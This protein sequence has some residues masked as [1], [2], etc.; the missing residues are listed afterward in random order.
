MGVL[1]T[2]KTVGTQPAPAGAFDCFVLAPKGLDCARVLRAAARA[3][4]IGLVQGDAGALAAGIRAATAAGVSRLGALAG[5]A[6]QIAALSGL[7][8]PA[9]D[10]VMAPVEVCLE[11]KPHV[12][13]LRRQGVR[14]LCIATRCEARSLDLAGDVDGYVLKGHECAGLVSEQTAF[15]LLQG[16]ARQTALPLYIQGGVTPATAAAARVGGAAGVVLDDEIMLL[17]ETGLA[18]ETLR[19][20]IERLSGSETLQVEHPT[21]D[22][23][24]RGLG[25]PGARQADE[26]TRKLHQIHAEES[27]EESGQEA[28]LREMATIADGFSWAQDASI[29]PGGQGLALAAPLARKYATLGRL[30]GAIG[31]AVADLPAAAAQRRALA[32]GG[33]LAEMFGTRYP[34]VQGPMT[35][36]SD[37]SDFSRHVGAAGALPMAALSLLKGADV[38]KLLAETRDQMQGMPWGVGMLGFAPKEVL[39]PQFAAVDQVRPDFA[40]IAGGRPD[41]VA[42]FEDMGIQTFVHASTVSL[43]CGNLEDGM[44]RFIIEGRECGGHIGPLTSFVLWGAIVEALLDHPVITKQGSKVQIVFAGGIH[45]AA[46]AAMVATLGEPLA[47]KGVKIGVLMGTGYLFTREIVASGAILPDYQSVALACDSTQ[48]LWEGPGY[49]NRCAHTPIAE[50]IRHKRR[51][52]EA[53]GASVTEVRKAIEAVSL[54]RLRMASKGIA[55]LGADSPITQIDKDQRYRE[56]MYMIGQVAAFHDQTLTIA[57][58]HQDVSAGSVAHLQ[59]FA[60]PRA[61]VAAEPAPP[62]ADIAIVGMGTLLPG[63]ETLAAYW[64][65]ILSGESAI[66]EVP[67]DRWDQAAYFN[68]DRSA[69]DRSY[70]RWGGFLED[71]EFDPL[72]YGIPP[73]TLGSVDPMQLLS[74]ELVSD[75]MKDIS[76]GAEDMGDRARIS[77]MLGFS[78]GIGEMGGAYVARTELARLLGADVP[79]ELLARL[80]EW[81]EDSFSGTLPNVSAGRVANRF[82]FG[83]TNVTVDAACASSLAAIYQGVMELESGRADMVVAGGIDTQ[84]S[85]F[86]YMCFAKTGAL[87]PRGVCNTFDAASDGIVISEGLAAIGLKRLA[88]AEAAGDR[89]YAVIKGVGASSDGRAKGLTA[90]L[91]KGQKRALRR[92]YNQAGYSPATVDL[93]EAHGTGTVAGDRAELETV[94]DVL[95]QEGAAPASAAIGSVKTLIGHTKASAGVA[96]LIKVALGLHHRVLPPHALVKTPNP[97]FGAE[98]MPLFISQ[99]P[100]PWI[101][102]PQMKRRAG[103]S[104]FGFGGTNFHVTLEEYADPLAD[105]AKVELGRSLVPVA[106]AADSRDGLVQSVAALI[107]ALT[108]GEISTPRA[109]AELAARLTAPAAP[110]RAGFVAD[111]LA[112][113]LEKLEGL[114]AHLDKGAALARGVHFCETPELLSGGKLAFVYPGQ[115]S[116]YPG[117]LRETA[118]LDPVMLA[119]LDRAEAVLAETPSFVG[120]SLA[121]LLYPGESFDPAQK[122]AQ[123]AALTQTQITQPA[124]GAVEAALTALL[125][126]LNVRPDM[127]AGH[128][129]GEFVAL[130][131]AGVLGYEDLMRLSEARGRAM[132]SNGDP[133]RPGAMAAVAADRAATEAAIKGMDGVTAVN[134]NS[135]SQTVIAGTADAIE[136]AMTALSEAG[137]DVRR[138]PVS[139]AFH[140]PLM[141][142]ARADFDKALAGVSWSKPQIPVYSNTR[143]GVHAKT[144]KAMRETMSAHLVSPVDFVG[145]ARSMADQ[146]A[147]VFVEVGPKSVL[148]SRLSEILGPQGARYISLDRSGGNA[149]GFMEGLL[150]LFVAG[151]TVDLAALGAAMAAPEPRALPAPAGQ[152]WLLNGGYARRADQPPRDVKAAAPGRFA[153]LPA[154]AAAPTAQQGARGQVAA[155][156]PV[157]PAAPEGGGTS[158]STARTLEFMEIRPKHF[159]QF[160]HGAGRPEVLANFHQM[161]G[162]F[163]RVQE[164]VMLAYLGQDAASAIQGLPARDTGTASV[165]SMPAPEPVLVPEMA[166]QPAPQPAAAAPAPV[167][168]A[169]PAA[170]PQP[171]PAAVAAAPAPAAAAD[172]S[173]D[174]LIAAF[175]T[176]VSEKTGYPEDALDPDQDL[177]AD[178]GVDSIKRMEILGALQKVLPAHKA[179]AMQAEMET[180][181]ELPTI[182]NIIE[183]VMVAGGDAGSGAQEAPSGEA[184]PFDLTGEADDHVSVVLP[185]FVQQAFAEPA[186]H[187]A[188]DLSPGA[189]VV[190]T[191]TEDQFH[192]A[193]LEALT[194]AGFEPVL[195]PRALMGRDALQALAAWAEERRQ[196]RPPEALIFLEGRDDYTRQPVDFDAWQA[197]HQR[198]SKGLY[199]VVQMLAP[200]LKEGGRIV[201][202]TQMGGLMGRNETADPGLRAGFAG[203]GTV[204]IVKVLSLEWPTC[205]SKAVDLDVTQSIEA[206]AGQLLRELSFQQGRREVGYPDGMRTIFRTEPRSMAPARNPRPMVDG[207]WV[208]LATGGARGITAECLRTLA[209]YNPRLVLLGRSPAPEPEAAE[210]RDLDMAGLRAHYLAEAKAAGDKPKPREIEARVTR[211]LG[212]RDM[213]RNL[214]DLAELGATVD[215]HAVDVCDAGAVKALMEGLYDRHGRIDM[216]VHGAGLIQDAFLE[217][218]SPESFDQVFDTKVDAA[219]HLVKNLRPETLQSI[220]FFTSVAG[221]YGNRGQI[222]YAAANETLNRFAWDLRRRWDH[223]TVKAINWG[224]WGQT[225]TGAGMVTPDVRAQFLARGIGMVEAGPGADFFFKEMFW[226]PAREVESVAWVADGETMEETVCALPARPD[227]ARVGAGMPLLS[228]ATKRENGKCEVIWRF[229]AVNAPYVDHHR[230]DGHGVLPYAGVMQMLAEVPRIFGLNQPVNT[231]TDMA[232]LNGIT[233][234]HG[235]QDLHFELEDAAEDGGRRVTVRSSHRPDRVAYRATIYLG[236]LPPAPADLPLQPVATPWDGPDLRAVYAGWLSHGPRFQ[237][238]VSLEGCDTTGIQATLLP[239]A[240]ADFVPHE[241]DYTWDFDPSLID[242]LLQMVWIWSRRIQGSST[243]P[244]SFARTRRFAGVDPSGPYTGKVQILSDAGDA[245]ILCD[246]RLYDCAGALVCHLEQFAGF[247]S[248]QLNR[249]SGG[250]QGGIPLEVQRARA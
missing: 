105:P 108:A 4:G 16:F 85:P 211:H 124:L 236:D 242:G 173:E 159:P 240:R 31:A 59:D 183:F 214:A 50:E 194:G 27:A 224:P 170:A 187:V 83:G 133:E 166:A 14:L 106:L 241:G 198:I 210:L 97:A 99:A 7:K 222:D 199:R 175:I 100:R 24:L 231:I 49:A 26:L 25:G 87:S 19:K 244:L 182:R 121:Q 185:R 53:G 107:A 174:G 137:L 117:M 20:R 165:A 245:N 197:L 249:L 75:V 188:R 110:V 40:I 169:A 140:S 102:R 58:L 144:L 46:S 148:S 44:R 216:L 155:P 203:G 212:H 101:A 56:G 35:R 126:K 164:N 33:P 119:H 176:L 154:G 43:I 172:L 232:M 215:Y 146:G 42:K 230:F 73:A 77:V 239:T 142:G 41:Q 60:D 205:S 1:E 150:A 219:F 160:E 68:A 238:L 52:M 158:P 90:P 69:R 88:D 156:E 201:V 217:K 234:E 47:R 57:D 120:A 10:L 63:S 208:V 145:M 15:V 115:G 152:L 104:S 96:G 134:F 143:G 28:C 86:G 209:P 218:K 161:M 74:L 72:A 9:L 235:A 94:S 116:Q 149:A 206:R 103:V 79:E 61:A 39:E 21:G 64:R 227:Q 127:V 225:T 22:F 62:P 125:G 71:V 114:L 131:A 91:P 2:R 6:T 13:K 151:A 171:A 48:S 111:T 30:M 118:L 38:E 136:A 139:Q 70:S 84:Q 29:K 54:G 138:V 204:G 122:Q 76:L 178:L 213:S 147:T 12:T 65:R 8:E 163:L 153:A 82:D 109:L 17:S 23:Y 37:V 135:P 55:R 237:S 181:S 168:T 93:F 228:Q 128:S 123:M 80:P 51:E 3:G 167:A 36:V 5:T 180:I 247:S 177:E 78:G 162:D 11:A 221:R 129:Y 229:D 45:D 195:L 81:T 248:S 233:L 246:I 95:F 132:V 192:L 243:L 18:D 200:D 207:D 196:D 220:C 130:H 226:A 193:V 34:I 250:W 223:V 184:R 186:D 32:E 113:A 66:R 67:E 92:A 141:Q 112:G 190:V 191:E 98:G 157:F 89:I 189:R 179:E 202:A